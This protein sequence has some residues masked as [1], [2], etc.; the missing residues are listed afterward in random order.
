MKKELWFA[1]LISLVL[2]SLYGTT[3]AL[4]GFAVSDTSISTVSTSANDKLFFFSIKTAPE[5]FSREKTLGYLS[6]VVENDQTVKLQRSVAFNKFTKI[7]KINQPA[8]SSANTINASLIPAQNASASS[9]SSQMNKTAIAAIKNVNQTSAPSTS[10]R[11]S[12][13][14]LPN[15]AQNQTIATTIATNNSSINASIAPQTPEN[16]TAVAIPISNVS[17]NQT[18]SNIAPS[19]A[20]SSTN[21]PSIIPTTNQSNNNNNYNNSNSNMTVNNTSINS[22]AAIPTANN[23]SNASNAST[24]LTNSSANSTTNAP[25]ILRTNITT[26][27]TNNTATNESNNT[28]TNTTINNI[29][30]INDNSTNVNNSQQPSDNNSIIQAE[31]IP[32]IEQ[33]V[34]N[35]AEQQ[36][37]QLDSSSKSAQIQTSSNSPIPSQT[38]QQLSP[39][40]VSPTAVNS[41]QQLVQGKFK[42][43]LWLG[44]P[45]VLLII[46]LLII[47]WRYERN[48]KIK[49]IKM[50]IHNEINTTN[51]SFEAI[52]S[53]LLMLGISK[54]LVIKAIA[55][56]KREQNLANLGRT[57]AGQPPLA[58]RQEITTPSL[59][60]S[61]ST[62]QS[63]QISQS[64]SINPQSKQQNNSNNPNIIQSQENANSNEVLNDIN[65][66]GNASTTITQTLL[67]IGI[68]TLLILSAC[69][70]ISSIGKAVQTA[71]KGI[72]DTPLYEFIDGNNIY[73]DTN[74][75][76][77]SG[78]NWQ[79]LNIIGYVSSK[80]APALI[81]LTRWSTLNTDNTNTANKIYYY[82]SGSE[83]AP[84][85]YSKDKIIGYFSLTKDENALQQ[86]SPTPSI[87]V[88]Q[89]EGAV[90]IDLSAK[91]GNRYKIPIKYTAPIGK[92]YT[93]VGVTVGYDPA[94]LKYVSFEK[95][96][97]EYS[98]LARFPA[99]KN[100]IDL[101]FKFKD[102][103]MDPKNI[104]IQ[105]KSGM[106]G[107]L[108]FESIIP[109]PD[110]TIKIIGASA[111]TNYNKNTAWITT[112]K[113][114]VEIKP[115]T[116]QTPSLTVKNS[117][118]SKTATNTTKNTPTK[119]AS[120]TNTTKTTA[121]AKTANNAN[122]T[123]TAP[124]P[125][126]TATATP[127]STAN[128]TK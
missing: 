54:T 78:S 87:A 33:P 112:G 105:P 9:A 108:I 82:T 23:L 4:T 56:V 104:I 119:P 115:S 99:S 117:T 63:T 48:K 15:T 47:V 72:Y 31:V 118:T 3:F 44:I 125:T 25:L 37:S 76:A 88:T 79:S 97:S 28:N 20:N 121:I 95:S 94:Q 128:A 83:I 68:I 100:A 39:E 42:W 12:I 26:N 101:Y 106:F 57:L 52:E 38:V 80:E 18:P 17:V 74:N 1:I 27:L 59:Q 81:P 64:F 32:P 29:L 19:P 66:K 73:Y 120:A 62:P 102:E 89:K 85:H 41:S 69:V 13:A 86:S 53:E 34:Q 11:S 5:G 50:A 96:E 90:S 110:T 113:D 45:I 55:E 103:T 35:P 111:S 21:T 71:G 51:K 30:S 122:K 84:S 7:T 14:V 36:S 46:L 58:N 67:I 65:N 114:K 107:F 6:P 61:N 127:T 2:L 98:F 8:T 49:K 77:P 40:T 124:K 16:K 70:G 92:N 75:A 123:T 60:Q 10:T 126:T 22:T 93:L 109:S 116:T 24:S 43:W 91:E